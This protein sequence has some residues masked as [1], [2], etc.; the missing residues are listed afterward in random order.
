MSVL[1]ARDLGPRV[2]QRHDAIEDRFA[3][4]GVFR[5][6]AEVAIAFELDPG[7]RRKFGQGRFHGSDD[8]GDTIGVDIVQEGFSLRRILWRLR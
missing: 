4:R 5:V 2:S 3:W 6:H 8:V 7:F 1:L